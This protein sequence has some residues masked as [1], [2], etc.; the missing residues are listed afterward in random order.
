MGKL[1]SKKELSKILGKSERTITEWRKLGMPV[2]SE[3]GRGKANVYD[4]SQI[5]EW[6][7]AQKL[8]QLDEEP[9]DPESIERKVSYEIERTRLIKAQADAQEMKNKIANQELAHYGLMAHLAAQSVNEVISFHDALP[10][11]LTRKLGLTP[12]QTEIVK[13]EVAKVANTAA[14]FANDEW[15][16]QKGREYEE[17]SGFKF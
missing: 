14:Y 15:I 16:E 2:E 5:I 10:L 13:I 6:L 9:K 8:E 11:T 17:I 4:T 1:V 12:K 7:I 3:S